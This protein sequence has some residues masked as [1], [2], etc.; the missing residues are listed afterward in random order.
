MKIQ[1]SVPAFIQKFEGNKEENKRFSKAKLKIFYIGET[2]DH[3]LFTKEFSD[4]L[5][6]SLPLTPVVGFYSDDDDDFRG[7]NAVQYV[8]GVVPETAA[9]EYVKDENDI[10]WAVTDVILYTERQDNIGRVASK[11]VGKQHSLE[12][13]PR[14]LKYKINHNELGG[15]KNIEFTEGSFIGLSVLGDKETPAF[16][17]SGFFNEND[18]IEKFRESFNSFLEYLNK[19]GGKIE[20][21]DLN[22]Y[23]SNLS[24]RIAQETQE[25]I[26]KA[27]EKA[28]ICGFIVQN[29]D[30]FVVIDRY[31][32]EPE[33]RGFYRYSILFTESGEVELQMP[34]KVFI[35]FL[36]ESEVKALEQPSNPEFA[37]ENITDAQECGGKKK[38]ACGEEVV[39]EEKP[40]EEEKKAP[41]E[42]ENSDAAKKRKGCAEENSDAV[43]KKKGCAEEIEEP[44]VEEK[45][46]KEVDDIEKEQEGKCKAQE[47]TEN[48]EATASACAAALTEAERIELEQYRRAEKEALINTYKGDLDDSVINEYLS[49]VDNYSKNTLEAEL[50]IAFRKTTANQ[51]KVAENTVKTF[52]II[53]LES[54]YDPSDSASAIK[55]YNY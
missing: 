50:A 10:T 34:E 1:T 37:A 45:P 2:A 41:D 23:F 49:K 29:S 11:I 16:S 8:Y 5:I 35:R 13:D 39:E 48:G 27:L 4:K 22:E 19:D 30:E 9:V 32:E 51:S 14:T 12:I 43:K 26:Y 53:E 54:N 42:E 25:A 33:M 20:V 15:L 7:H 3:R 44:S 21:F 55:K 6:K 31:D 38:K 17:G 18:F 28:G 52:S 36:N 24:S 46:K 40:A 47:T